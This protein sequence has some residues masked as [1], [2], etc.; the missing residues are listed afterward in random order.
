MPEML[1]PSK[2]YAHVY[3]IVRY[4]GFYTD[5]PTPANVQVRVTVKKIVTDAE[6]AASEVRRLNDMNMDKGSFYFCQV[7]RFEDVP[8]ET[9]P[10]D[11]VKEKAQA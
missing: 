1:K 3:A 10:S 11:A 8:I 6:H 7:T 2:K 9:V 4:D 5:A